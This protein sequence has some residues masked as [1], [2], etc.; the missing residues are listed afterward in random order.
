MKKFQFNL[1]NPRSIKKTAFRTKSQKTFFFETFL[2]MF[3]FILLLIHDQIEKRSSNAKTPFRSKK[4]HLEHKATKL[5]FPKVFFIYL[6][7]FLTFNIRSNE[8]NPYSIGNTFRTESHK[9]DFPKNFL[10][11]FIFFLLLI[12]VRMKKTQFEQKNPRK[13]QN[14]LF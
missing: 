2:Y 12:S 14:L 11:M 9:I 10:K 4:H 3:P 8:K 5:T 6:H 7:F 1:K 13:P